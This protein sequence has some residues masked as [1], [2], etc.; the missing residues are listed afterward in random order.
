MVEIEKKKNAEA[1]VSSSL[2]YGSSGAGRGGGDL[3]N[4]LWCYFSG[5]RDG[6]VG[7]ALGG[8]L[9]GGPREELGKVG[10]CCFFFFGGGWGRERERERKLK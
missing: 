7:A 3:L 6:L 8:R 10:C 1:L 9:L 4:I 5:D 2:E